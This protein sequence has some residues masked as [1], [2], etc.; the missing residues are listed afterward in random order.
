MITRRI[1]LLKE[2]L[3]KVNQKWSDIADDMTEIPISFGSLMADE[4]DFRNPGVIRAVIVIPRTNSFGPLRKLTVITDALSA[5][6]EAE[7]IE[8]G[9]P[10]VL[11][12]LD[13]LDKQGLNALLIE[14]G[15]AAAARPFDPLQLR[16][17]D[18]FWRHVA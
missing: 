12:C 18:W 9:M 13:A 15:P 7:E 5:R 10:R 2:E 11:D 16:I 4:A 14:T 3:E 17:R 1:E 8:W 6:G